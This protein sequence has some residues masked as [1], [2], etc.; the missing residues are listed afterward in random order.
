[1]NYENRLEIFLQLYFPSEKVDKSGLEL[2]SELLNEV[3][4]LLISHIGAK[5]NSAGKS[6][7]QTLEH[8][9]R[10]AID[11]NF[12]EELKMFALSEANKQLALLKSGFI[13]YGEDDTEIIG[14]EQADSSETEDRDAQRQIKRRSSQEKA[15]PKI[16]ELPIGP[17]KDGIVKISSAVVPDFKMDSEAV[18]FL[19]LCIQTFSK[20]VAERASEKFSQKDQLQPVNLKHVLAEYFG[21]NV[22]KVAIS[23]GNRCLTL[24]ENGLLAFK[25]RKTSI[26]RGPAKVKKPIKKAS[27]KSP[28]RSP[29]SKKRKSSKIPKRPPSSKKRRSKSPKISTRT[30]KPSKKTGTKKKLTSVRPKKIAKVEKPSSKPCRKSPQRSP[31]SKKKESPKRPPSSTKRRSKSSSTGTRRT[32]KPSERTTELQKFLTDMMSTALAEFSR[33]DVNL[34]V[35]TASFVNGILEDVCQALFDIIVSHTSDAE[36]LD[37]RCMEAALLELLPHELAYHALSVAL[38]AVS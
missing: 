31:V 23:E 28:Q 24:Y 3:N 8:F 25:P 35:E 38:N 4:S 14:K 17:F 12:P 22:L 11:E 37:I 16:A 36:E 29:V 27:R 7:R 15:K 34:A 5:C 10:N 18:R 13:V 19:A 26:S 20:M 33:V 1:M 9:A 30:K 32:K 6:N 21:D 2:I